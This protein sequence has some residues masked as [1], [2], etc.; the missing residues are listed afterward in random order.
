MKVESNVIDQFIKR[1]LR[2]EIAYR[3]IPWS[4]I[5]ITSYVLLSSRTDFSLMNYYKSSIENALGII[6]FALPIGVIMLFVASVFKDMEVRVGNVWGQ[7]HTLGKS[8]AIVRKLCSEILL[9]GCGVSFSLILITIITASKVIYKEG[10]SD[11]HPIVSLSVFITLML[12]VFVFYCVFYIHCRKE[13]ATFLQLVIR[14]ARYI[15]IVYILAALV[16]IGYVYVGF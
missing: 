8:G 11:T 13:G 2:I 7:H 4:I 16:C 9:W 5:T 3:M 15:P 10:V 1:D 6:N 12:M 14:E